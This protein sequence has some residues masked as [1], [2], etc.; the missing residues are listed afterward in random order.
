MALIRDADKDTIKL[1]FEKMR[2]NV[3]ILVFTSEEN[4]DYCKETLEIVNEL[5]DLGNKI[6]LET[7]DLTKN[8][9]VAEKYGVDKA[10]A[11]VLEA[12]EKR[13]K[14]FGIPA[15][16]EFTTLVEDIV[17]ISYEKPELHE[18]TR[19]LLK[20]VDRD[21]HIM[22]FVTPTCPY[23]PA[24]VRIAHKFAFE[25]PKISAE[26]IEAS[27]FPDLAEKYGVFSVPKV[28]INNDVEFEGALPEE[29]FAEHVLLAIGKNI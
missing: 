2:N 8:R 1:E 21:V 11:I 18:K 29:H 25:N 22:V 12:G 7:Y 3:K 19:A 17:E 15:G 6:S 26:M 10:P 24:A 13:A 23:C 16:Y 27:E 28:V 14:F 20:N 5:K 4:C 9:D